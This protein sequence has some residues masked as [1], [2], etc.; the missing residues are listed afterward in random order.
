[1]LELAE[2][3][4]DTR[5]A[6]SSSRLFFEV[7]ELFA[8]SKLEFECL[9]Q[10]R[11]VYAAVPAVRTACR[12]PGTRRTLC[13]PFDF[14]PVLPLSLFSLFFSPKSERDRQIEIEKVV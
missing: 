11:Q 3:P 6:E 12:A 10:R 9:V 1:M 14:R 5:L 7:L 4:S 13:F 2:V 8:D